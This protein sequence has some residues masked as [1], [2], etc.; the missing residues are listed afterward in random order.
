MGSRGSCFII[1]YTIPLCVSFGNIAYFV[2]DYITG[3]ISLLLA[4]KFALQRA[5][6]VWDSGAGDEYEDLEILE[7]AN[8]IASTSN[9]ILSFRRS[10]CF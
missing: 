2:P 5:L 6:A 4:H 10:K 9:P 7:T 1:V 3:V 8:L